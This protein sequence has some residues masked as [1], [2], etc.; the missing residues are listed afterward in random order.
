MDAFLTSVSARFLRS[1]A[2]Q[3]TTHHLSSRYDRLAWRIVARDQD[4]LAAF[5]QVSSQ[6]N[7]N[8]E[9]PAKHMHRKDRETTSES[10]QSRD[11]ASLQEKRVHESNSEEYI[12]KVRKRRQDENHSWLSR[13]ANREPSASAEGRIA[14]RSDPPARPLAL[15]LRIEAARCYSVVRIVCCA[16]VKAVRTTSNP[17]M[18][19]P[20]F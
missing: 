1:N 5:E 2:Q 17:G 16:R 15:R 20:P 11:R 8:A 3:H 13:R 19:A 4:R 14:E 10:R 18:S 6:L 9:R 7:A 12:G